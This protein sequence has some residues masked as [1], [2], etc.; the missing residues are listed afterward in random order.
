MLKA[1]LKI[2]VVIL[3]FTVNSFAQNQKIPSD[4]TQIKIE[5][6]KFQQDYADIKV[7]LDNIILKLYPLEKQKEYLLNKIQELD[8]KYGTWAQKYEQLKP[9]SKE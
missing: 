2:L 3:F 6:Q 7:E 1:T 8:A 4:T 5:M 9:K